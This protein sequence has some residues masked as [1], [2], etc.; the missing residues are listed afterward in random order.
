MHVAHL[1]CAP[2][3]NMS[4]ERAFKEI[5]RSLK[6]ESGTI[7]AD[8]LHLR[9]SYGTLISEESTAACSTANKQ[10]CIVASNLR[11]NTSDCNL[12]GNLRGPSALFHS[13]LE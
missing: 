6:A 4:E 12:A 3:V 2:F 5:S 13:R 10:E 8:E 11:G 9:A 7:S 1:P